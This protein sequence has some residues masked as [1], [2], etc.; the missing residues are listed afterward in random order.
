VAGT[1]VAEATLA[2]NIF[3]LRK[4]AGRPPHI[5]TVPKFGYRFV[6]AMRE[7]RGSREKSILVSAAR[8]PER[9]QGAGI[10]QRRV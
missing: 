3:A 4:V 1:S 10:L 9:R 7:R 6:C 2:Q 8:E 5:E